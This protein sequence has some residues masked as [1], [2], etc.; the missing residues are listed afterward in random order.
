MENVSSECKV[1]LSEVFY[2][3]FLFMKS[4]RKELFYNGIP[5]NG[6]EVKIEKERFTFFRF[7]LSSN[8]RFC[9]SV[10]S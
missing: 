10:L 2:D 1:I 8:I 3:Y 7:S 4:N 9:L 5:S 6:V